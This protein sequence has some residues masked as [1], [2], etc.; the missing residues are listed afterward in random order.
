MDKLYP[1]RFTPVYKD[2]LW[3]GDRIPKI[4]KRDMPEGVYAESW[5]ISTHPDGATVIANGPLAGK[6]LG[7]L[8]PER[9]DE[10]LGSHVKGDD[11]P[12][13]I[14]LIDARD[15]LS[16]QVHPNDGNAAEVDGQPKTEMWYF[17]EGDADANIYCGLKPGIGKEEFLKAMEDKTF[18][19][20]LQII[21]AEPGEAVFVPGGRV[22]AI[23]TGCLILEIQQNSNTTYRL[24]DWDRTDA[25]GNSRELHIDK[26]LQVIDWENNGDPHCDVHGT[27]I[28]SCEYFQLDRHE[29]SEETAF[30]NLGK[31]FQ[32]LFIAGG[33]GIIRWS[34]GEEK[35]F[36][37]Q[38]WLVPAALG[39]FEIIPEDA[40]TVLCTTIP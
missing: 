21:P 34:D 29:L 1:L 18:A 33:E 8:L 24:Y 17:L 22:H 20:I 9:K 40:M 2:Y 37:G 38:S 6:T 4:F 7:D 25:N 10:I 16:V 15:K 30:P 13:L 5:E 3:G 27:T 36:L 32:A 12:L 28:Q 26:A 11:F 31:S 14:K 39:D 23:G 35:L 19:D